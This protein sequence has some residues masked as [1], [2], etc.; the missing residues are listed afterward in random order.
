MTF[1]KRPFAGHRQETPRPRRARG[2]PLARRPVLRLALLALLA[3]GA[4][5]PARAHGGEH[6]LQLD[7]VVIGDYR[8][9]LWTGPSV[10]RPGQI[11][12]ESLVTSAGDD[13]AA[14]GATV[15]YQV[16]FDNGHHRDQPMDLAAAP[17]ET[18]S[19]RNLSEELHLAVVDLRQVGPYAVR[20]FVTD[21]QGGEHQAALTLQVVPDNPWLPWVLVLLSLVTGLVAVA[22]AWHTIRRLG[23]WWRGS[24][25]PS[26]S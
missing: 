23:F 21:P 6:V 18:L 16:Q 5:R 25:A 14:K 20:V 3:C 2:A 17:V 13:Q 7:D 1:T 22:F 15:R 19:E 24:L 12:L 10:L 26:P 9:N 8:L 4:P 11:L